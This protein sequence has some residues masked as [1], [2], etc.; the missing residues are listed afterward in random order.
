[1]D[2]LVSVL[3]RRCILTGRLPPPFSF[4]LVLLLGVDKVGWY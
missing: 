1:M 2:E 3:L 4:S